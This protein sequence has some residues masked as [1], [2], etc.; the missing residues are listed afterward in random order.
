M[1]GKYINRYLSVCSSLNGLEAAKMRDANDDF[2]LSSTVQKFNLTFDISWKVMKDIIVNY[3]GVQTFASGSPRETLRTAH[4]VDLIDDDIWLDMLD[5]RNALA[6]D[7][8]GNLAK[9]C[10]GK[11]VN[12][13]IPVLKEFQE[14]A[15][16]YMDLMKNM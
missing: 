13:Y 9:E 8:D 15:G 10:F 14:K 7:Y 6:H 2:V 1:E 5:D 11:I 12:E 3:H 4:S 16:K